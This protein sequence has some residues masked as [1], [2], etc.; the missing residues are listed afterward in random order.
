MIELLPLSTYSLV[1]SVTPGPNNILLT[2]SGANFGYRRSLPHILGI[3]LGSSSQSYL[4][5]LGLGA[6]FQSY[7]SLQT[8][9]QIVGTGYMLYLA[10]Q[11]FGVS[12][13]ESGIAKPVSFWEAAAFQYVNPKIWVKSVTIATVFMPTGMAPWL[14]GL[15]VFV[16]TLSINFPSVSMWTLFGVAIKRHLTNERRRL[17]FNVTMATLLVATAVVIAL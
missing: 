2:A 5:C 11:L 9:L 1:M 16:V 12:I 7:P 15:Y 6:V 14:A 17:G 8:A 10:W 4:V 3:G 13:R